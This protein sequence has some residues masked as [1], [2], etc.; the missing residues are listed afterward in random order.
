MARE[1]QAV[2]L[3][4][5]QHKAFIA[6][7]A[8]TR[9]AER[10]TLAYILTVRAGMRIGSVAGLELE[11][12][13]DSEG[14][15]KQVVVLRRK[16]TKGNKTNTAYL[17]HPEVQEAIS[18]YMKVR[19]RSRSTYLVLSQ[20]GGGLSAHS[21]S[22]VM[23][24]HYKKAGIEGASSHSGRRTCITNWIKAGGDIVAVSKLAGHSSVTTT[25]RYVHHNQEELLK[26][27]SLQQ[28]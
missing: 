4:E 19:P 5:E 14:Q 12:L 22:E 25:Q 2:A 3:T 10:D 11:D 26:L 6:Y 24:N 15:Q 20:K 8:T 9:H 23:A 13:F 27:V 28:E 1:G 7:L 18:K 16:I 21:L 17:S